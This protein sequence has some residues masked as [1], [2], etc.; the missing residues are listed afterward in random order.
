MN[1]NQILF[2]YQVITLLWAGG[3]VVRRFSFFD[4]EAQVRI[5]ARSIFSG[6]LISSTLVSDLSVRFPPLENI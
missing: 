2:F 5:S 6:F 3:Q 4:Y 1:V